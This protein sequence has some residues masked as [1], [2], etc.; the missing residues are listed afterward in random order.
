[1]HYSE[2]RTRTLNVLTYVAAGLLVSAILMNFLYPGTDLAQ[3]NAQRIFYIHL[4]SFFGSFLLFSGAVFAG[5]QY[6]RT[7]DAKWDT[8]GVST[9]EVGL[10]LSLINIVTGAI[11]ARPIWNTW[12]TWD[13]RLTSVTIMWLSYAAYLMLRV[14]VEDP[15]RR[16][17]FAAVYGMLAFTSVILTIVIIRVRPDTIHPVV[18]G[19]STTSPDIEGDFDLSRRI[20]ITTLYNIGVFL[21]ISVVLAWHRIRLQNRMDAVEERKMTLLL[22]S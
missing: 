20:T 14:G 15:E 17:R 16:R 5:I 9:I 1:M 21:L 19:P 7:R 22:N 2:S 8:L 11:W 10:G 18:A 6:L 4:G 3:G 12:W 13:P